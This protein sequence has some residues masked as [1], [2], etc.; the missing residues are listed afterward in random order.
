MH[1]LHMYRRPSSGHMKAA[2]APAIEV[3]LPHLGP[4]A[5]QP[6][7]RLSLVERPS[8]TLV[9]ERAPRVG[10]TT[11][12]MVDRPQPTPPEKAAEPSAGESGVRPLAGSMALNK[13]LVT[14][15]KFAG[16][17]VLTIILVG[18]VSYLAT[19]IF[20]FT[21][22][23]WIAPTVLS[24]TDEHVLQLDALASQE[25]AAKGTLVTKKLEL[26]AQLQDA[27]RIAEMETAFQDA[28]RAAMSTDLAD[29]RMELARLRGL[30]GKYASAKRT[31]QGSNEA[32]SG[33]QRG[34]L[35]AQYQAH[36]IDTDQMLT[37]NYEL[38]QI[39][40]AN[41][42]LD[43]RN[44]EIDTRAGQLQREVESLEGASQS[45]GGGK[46]TRA[47]LSYEI[48]HIKRD[49][50]TSVLAAAK[51]NDDAE[52][53]RQSIE[54]LDGIIAQHDKLLDTIKNSPYEMAA[55]RGL[56]MAFVPY[57]NKA[58]VTAGQSVYGCALGFVWC[59]KVGN[60]AATIDGEVLGKHP[61]HNKD[62]RG[63]MVKLQL[64]DASWIE[65]PVLH[66]G[67]RPLL[68]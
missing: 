34:E 32:F 49:F 65:K 54:T 39:A 3:L 1:T 27:Q 28:F 31:I 36:V 21:N 26:Q 58:S 61:L 48:L 43:E 29:R 2:T 17:G 30:L 23:H 14:V 35:G 44:V 19:E 5:T 59:K 15:Y 68:F 8:R 66:V 4:D 55:D 22:T 12:P 63:V 64:D 42:S 46:P 13:L 51:A 50:D 7:R 18:L 47:Q 52:A 53:L 62:I 24:P 25:M 57:D 11:Q 9:M 60:V 37:G 33:L 67:R 10:E 38:A 6:M 41:L 20:Y 56:T 16:F 40:G 45:A